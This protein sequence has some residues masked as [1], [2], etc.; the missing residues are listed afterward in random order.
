MSKGEL[1]CPFWQL[2]T[3]PVSTFYNFDIWLGDLTQPR[4]H[5]HRTHGIKESGGLLELGRERSIEEIQKEGNI[6]WKIKQ[7]LT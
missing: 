4:A 2:L 6:I 1:V 5:S 3:L 7:K